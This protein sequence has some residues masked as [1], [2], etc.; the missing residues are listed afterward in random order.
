MQHILIDLL[1][2]KIECVKCKQSLELAEF[3]QAS[4]M[5]KIIDRFEKEHEEC[6]KQT[7]E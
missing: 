3:V 5:R 4:L 7:Q 2:K 1:N 6:L